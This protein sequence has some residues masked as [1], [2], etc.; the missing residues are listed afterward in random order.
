M[1]K[2]EF[3]ALQIVT[4]RGDIKQV[5]PSNFLVRSQSDPN[6][7]YQVKWQKYHW[8]CECPDYLKHHKKCKHT[9]AIAYYQAM[10]GITDEVKYEGVR[11][12]RCNSE[13]NITKRGIR[14]NRHGPMQ[15]YYCKRCKIRFTPRTGF[16][17]M[18][19]KATTVA[20]AIDLFFRGVSTRQICQ[21]LE[22][23]YGTSITHTT[24]HNW[25]KK[26]VELASRYVQTMHPALSDRWHADETVI[27]VGG[28]HRALW[29]LLDSNK[30]F[31][32]ATHISQG[33]GT[34]DAR[35]LMKNGINTSGNAPCEI[36]T[37]GN[38]AYVDAIE[39]ELVPHAEGSIVHVQGPLAEALN[40]KMEAL[41]GTVKARTKA[42]GH[43]GSDKGAEVFAKGFSTHHNFVKRHKTLGKTPA[44][45]SGLA[46]ASWL[47]LIV[48]ASDTETN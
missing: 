2:R 24:V 17:G 10:S 46:S 6:R 45:E 42:M 19:N 30:R 31:L 28:R 39:K 9:H 7:W 29:M 27:R 43:F 18:K 37:D 44:E 32:I 1:K 11:C 21:H 13:D 40:N 47:Q 26:Y 38:P 3:M 16:H 4:K 22:S 5:D 41:C 34:Q 35:E 36:I 25:L 12:T 8:E 48:A 20:V 14:H 15:V 33:R 23:C